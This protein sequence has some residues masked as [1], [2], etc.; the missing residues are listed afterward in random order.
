MK[1]AI[2]HKCIHMVRGEI[3]PFCIKED[4]EGI[5]PY[6]INGGSFLSPNET[7]IFSYP[8]YKYKDK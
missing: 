6:R 2:C 1:R 8:L 7:E 4:E 3:E 5:M